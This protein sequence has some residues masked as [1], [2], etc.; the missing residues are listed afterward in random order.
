ME[1]RTASAGDVFKNID[2]THK[3]TRRKEAEKKLTAL[4]TFLPELDVPEATKQYLALMTSLD[5]SLA[6][7]TIHRKLQYAL[8]NGTYKSIVPVF[9][10]ALCLHLDNACCERGFSAMSDIKTAKRN[11]HDK[12]HFS[13]RLLQ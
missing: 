5:V 4:K 8:R 6:H 10:L 12:F 3:R 1:V 9:Q 13:I 7:A 11:K 2:L